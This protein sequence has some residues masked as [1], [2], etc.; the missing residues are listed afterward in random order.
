MVRHHLLPAVAALLL[1]LFNSALSAATLEAHV[2]KKQLI[3]SEHITL[4][5]ALINSDTRLRAQGINPNIDLTLLTDNFEL[6][7]PQASNRYS[8]F[9]NRGRSSSEVTVTLFP[10]KVGELTI[11][12]FTVDGESSQPIIITVLPTSVE[13]RPLVFTRS[14]TLKSA[15]WLREQTIVYLDL[16]HR[17]ELK[18]AKL[19]GAIESEPKLQ[20]QLSQ[21]PQ[22]D[23]TEE[24]NGISYNVTRTAWAVAPAINQTIHLYLPDVWVETAA[25]EQLRF[26]FN[27]ITIETMPLPANVP[28]HTLIG[29]PVITQSTINQEITQHQSFQ[30]LITLQAPTNL[31][32][33]SATPPP[34]Q[35]PAGLKVYSESDTRKIVEESND[36]SSTVTYRYFIMPLEAGT[37]RIPD[38]TI[39][40]FDPERSIMS[41]VTLVGQPFTVTAAPLPATQTAFSNEEPLTQTAA[42]NEIASSA[43]PWKLATLIVTLAWLATA[44]IVWRQHQNK[45]ATKTEPAQIAHA[46]TDS[47]HP[48]QAELLAVFGTRTLDQGQQQW[49]A[50]HGVDDE[51]RAIIIQVQQ[52]YYGSQKNKMANDHLQKQ[53]DSLI[54]K[55]KRKQIIEDHSDNWR[56]EA[57][58][59]KQG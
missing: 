58:T 30:L 47:I 36:G 33:L 57:F 29:R 59:A 40:Y 6:S 11:P 15:L 24:H 13:N 51:M 41:Q 10:K 12:P 26:P 19:G 43:L 3:I 20:I 5:L 2:D 16:Y 32:N 25:G 34:I 52:H 37:Y 53:I 39:P 44:L 14:G 28:A 22:S 17:V 21:L 42:E 46:V 23:R 45:K 49:E 38:I 56:P 27:D 8:P 48:L 31:I 50:L 4:T 7:I 18:S 54:Q 35:F 55:I 9:R 1:V